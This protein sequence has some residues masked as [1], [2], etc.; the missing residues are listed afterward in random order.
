MP[1]YVI[2]NFVL[3]CVINAFTPGP[4]NILAL[5]TVTNYGW[6][7]GRPLFFGIFTGYYVVQLICA[8][9]VFGIAAFL[10]SVLGVM[11]YIGAAYILWLA[12]HIAISKP[13]KDD[14]SRSA[15]YMKGFLLQ[16][17]NVKIYLFGM[18]ALTGY[19]TDYHTSLTALVLVIAELFIATLGS[20]ATLTWI[21]MGA[22][23]QKF[24]LK[25]YRIINILL[26]LTLVECII[27]ILK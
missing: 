11:K 6:K 9:F 12:I 3:Y 27:S 19:I 15:S 18:T 24:Y 8:V 1:A 5:N 21:G 7:K 10:P 17:V 23:I 20:F 2:G 22:L 14:D 4:G 25:H 26:A 13:E 16:F